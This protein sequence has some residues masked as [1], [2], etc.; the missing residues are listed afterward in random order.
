MSKDF[1]GFIIALS[2]PSPKSSGKMNLRSITVNEQILSR[3][4]EKFEFTGFLLDWLTSNEWEPGL[5][6][7][8]TYEGWRWLIAD[9]R[10][11]FLWNIRFRLNQNWIVAR[12]FL[13]PRQYTYT[14]N[15]SALSYPEHKHASLPTN[16]IHGNILHIFWGWLGRRK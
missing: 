12:I 11:Y 5:S 8:L 4:A 6:C 1:Q 9:I 15:V 3:F 10:K 14:I 7:Y 2:I 16:G 13:Y